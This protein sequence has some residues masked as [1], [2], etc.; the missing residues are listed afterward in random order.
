MR[1]R[2]SKPKGKV[3]I[4]WSSNFAYA[5]GLIASDGCL[6]DDRLHISFTS[7]DFEQIENFM[8]CLGITV[9]VGQTVSNGGKVA[10]RIQFGDVL[11]YKFLES[12]G[13][14]SAKSMTIGEVKIPDEYF[15]DFFRGCFDG[16]GC[17]YSYWDQRW[18]SSFMFYVSLASAS[19]TFIEWIQGAIYRLLKL[20]GHISFTKRGNG[21]Y[22]LRY[23]KREGIV[24][25]G[26]MYQ[27]SGAITLS[28]KYLKIMQSL[29]IVQRHKS[30]VLT[31]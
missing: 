16:D 31:K 23:A 7:K 6:Y 21:Y 20:H 11:F 3:K 2:G 9:K 22:Q 5:I 30:D 1:K 18:S 26:F 15:L 19:R 25:V 24:L 29:A 4:E 13:V 10:F 8:R 17:S 12:I 27:K 28:R 14:T